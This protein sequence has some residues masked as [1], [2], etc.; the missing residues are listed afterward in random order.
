MKEKSSTKSVLKIPK[1]EILEEEEE[2]LSANQRNQTT[3]TDDLE[4]PK[5]E[6][7]KTPFPFFSGQEMSEKSNPENDK[8]RIINKAEL[9]QCIKHYIVIIS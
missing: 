1:S 7:S 2:L 6:R 9:K 3:S 5:D 8:V 4:F